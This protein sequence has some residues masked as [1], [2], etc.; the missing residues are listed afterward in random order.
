MWKEFRE[1]VSRGNVLDLAVAVVIGAAFTAIVTS[2]VQDLINP[3]IGLIGGNDFSNYYVVLS[4]NVEPGVSYA[5]AR[6]QGAVLGYGA[7][8]SAII[9]FLI[10]AA[11]VFLFVKGANT[12]QRRKKEEDEPKAPELSKDQQLLTEIRDLLQGS[13]GSRAVAP[14]DGSSAAD[15]SP[16]G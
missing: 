6:E 5:V 10:I 7:F 11:A 13:P 3:I 14:P 9:N 15:R 12:L 4:G 8:V 16:R 2:L 1:F